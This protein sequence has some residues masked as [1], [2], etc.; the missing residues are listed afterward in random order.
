MRRRLLLSYITLTLVVLLLLEIPLGLVYA[1]EQRRRLNASV[2]RDALALSVRAE[3]SIEDGNVAAV[4]RL[5]NEYRDRTGGRVI[6]VRPNGR[7]LADS[8]AG[9][10]IGADYSSRPEIRSAL[11]GREAKG[12]RHSDSLGHDILYFAVPVVNG[13]TLVGVL[14][15]TYPTSFVDA[16]IRRGWL[17]LVGIGLIALLVV[18][19]V[20]LR[21]ARQITVPVDRLVEATTRFGEGDLAARA[22]VPRGPPEIAQLTARFND[23]ADQLE[24]LVVR[25]RDFV[26]D[27]SHQLRTPLAALRLRLEN[28]ELD[29][30]EE[31]DAAADVAG[32]L[33]E[34]S[35]LSRIVD[36]L[37]QLARAE[38]A[39]DGRPDAVDVG[40]V[41]QGRVDAW[42]AFADE[43]EVRFAVDADGGLVARSVPGRLEQVLDNLVANAIDASPAGGTIRVT[44]AREGNR[45]VVT[46]ADDGQGMS[47]DERDRAF[48]RFWRAGASAGGTGLGLAIVHRLVGAD[49]GAVRL[50]DGPGGGLAVVVELPQA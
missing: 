46:V 17:V 48:D 49:H 11:R 1:Q 5:V 42:S 33:V 21:L 4:Q 26:A 8:S 13:P 37:L 30:P 27:A 38:R 6:V 19:L 44:G 28:L 35:R 25:Q 3:E 36:G 34:V 50:E 14:R 23:T 10:T 29:V 9:A 18:F 40:A 12:T 7:L 24:R 41:V 2:E 43:H 32:S 47:A 31:S 45:V 22:D 15:V 16:R 20:S 39:E